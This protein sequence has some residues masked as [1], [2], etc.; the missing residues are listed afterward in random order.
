MFCSS[1]EREVG[2][3]PGRLGVDDRRRRRDVDRFGQRADLQRDRQIDGLADRDD[4]VLAHG[5]REALERQRQLVG[6]RARDS[7]SGTC[8]PRRRGRRRAIRA[9][10][11]HRDAGQHPALFVRDRAGQRA[12]AK[13]GGRRATPPGASPPPTETV[14]SHPPSTCHTARPQNTGAGGVR[15]LGCAVGRTTPWRD[16]WRSSRAHVIRWRMIV[17]STPNGWTADLEL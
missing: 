5:G 15:A 3:G 10:H 16:G 7:G 11:R 6:P 9:S 8:P 2:R 17:G 12:A 14:S 13:L 4:H 1:S